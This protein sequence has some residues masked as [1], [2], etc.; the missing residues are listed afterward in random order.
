MRKT[1]CKGF[2]SHSSSDKGVKAVDGELI[3]L[4]GKWLSEN[5]KVDYFS[6][7]LIGL[8]GSNPTLLF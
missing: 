4:L 3:T 8:V 7:S 1:V 5:E 2:E 6:S